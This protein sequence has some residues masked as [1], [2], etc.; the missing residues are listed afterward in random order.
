[1]RKKISIV[2][3]ALII[4]SIFAT[5]CS[6]NNALPASTAS[7]TPALI[8][9]TIV[10]TLTPT[11]EATTTG[12][13]SPKEALGLMFGKDSTFSEDGTK[14]EVTLKN[15]YKSWIE[16]NSLICFWEHE[17]EKCIVITSRSEGQCHICGVHIQGAIFKKTSKEWAMIKFE[18]QIAFV[19]S[20][21]YI[22]KGELIHIGDQKYAILLRS[23]Y[24]NLG[25]S[26]THTTIIAET[27]FLMRRK[28]LHGNSCLN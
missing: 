1:M 5:G 3:L 26:N 15:G 12:I 17:S 27:N 25:Y 18:P 8:T 22:S 6:T 19:G 20:F 7:L 2:F 21:G 28:I 14:V 23:G 13:I 24:G 16:I 11:P 9:E 10:A 4:L